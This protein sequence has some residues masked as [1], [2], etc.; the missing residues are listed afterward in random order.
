MGVKEYAEDELGV[1]QVWDDA[2]AAHASLDEAMSKAVEHRARVRSLHEAVEDEEA[3]LMARI[4]AEYSER[5]A[6]ERERL[7]RETR[8]TDKDLVR[9]RAVLLEA[10]SDLDI[11]EASV[12]G[13]KYRLRVLVAR[14]H[15]LG[16]LLELY[17]AT[18]KD[19]S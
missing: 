9:L 3:N 15:E 5:T 1:H 10:Q 19:D 7:F 14:M 6:T 8:R 17:A 12:E 11:A 4:A 13:H 18:K 16:G 2:N